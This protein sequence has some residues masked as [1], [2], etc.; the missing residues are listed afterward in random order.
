MPA[1]PKGGKRPANA[2][3]RAPVAMCILRGEEPEDCGS[4]TPAM[5][6]GS[7]EQP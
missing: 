1:G 5:A 2:I 7:S 4:M 3:S 6:A